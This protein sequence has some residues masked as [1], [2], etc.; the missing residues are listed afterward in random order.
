M[1]VHCSWKQNVA[2]AQGGEFII[3]KRVTR[4]LRSKLGLGQKT[5]LGP[6]PLRLP[7]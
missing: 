4:D 6:V 1:A 3:A 2:V 5:A 7:A